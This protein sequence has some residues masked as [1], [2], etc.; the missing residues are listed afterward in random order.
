MK[1]IASFNGRAAAERT[2]SLL[3]DGM[4]LLEACV[5]GVVLVEDDP[6]ELTVG[7]GGLPNADGVVELDAAVMDGRM[8]RAA[9]VA[10]LRNIRHPSRVALRLLQNSNRVLL[11]GDGAFQ[12]AVAEGFVEENLL[13]EKARKIWEHWRQTKDADWRP[14][15][16]AQLDPEVAAYIATHSERPWGTVHLAAMDGQGN[17]ACVTSTSGHAFKPPGRVGDSPIVGAGLYADNEAGTCGS[18]GHGES[19]LKNCSSFLAVELMRSGAPPQEAGLE[20][21]RRIER[22][23]TQHERD[24][25]GRIKMDVRLYLLAGDGRHAGVSLRPGNKLAVVDAA[26]SR[27]EVCAALVGHE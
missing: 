11:A 2:F 10:A 8:H 18:L 12:F 6:D 14:A 27:V 3:R 5:E 7:Y 16:D 22:H 9:G 17:V 26:G 25:S 19:N 23:A 13:T 4:D 24:T 15:A 1:V 21:L 20:A